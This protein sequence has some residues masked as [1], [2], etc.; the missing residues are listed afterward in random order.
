[1]K[2]ASEVSTGQMFAVKILEKNHIIKEKKIEWVEREKNLL[3]KLSH[4]AIITLYYTFQDHHF[5]YFVLELCPGG[6]FLDIIRKH[7]GLSIPCAVHYM[8]E[9]TSAVEYLHSMGVIHRDLKPENMLLTADNHIKLIDFGTAKEI[10]TGPS[11]RTTS[12][13]GTA[14]YLAPEILSSRQDNGY[15]LLADVWALGCV[16]YQ[17]LAGRC[18]FRAKVPLLIFQLIQARNFVYPEGFPEGPPMDLVEQLLNPNE[19]LRLGAKGYGEIK[20]HPFFASLT[21]WNSLQQRT[22]PPFAPPDTP[23]VWPPPPPEE[24]QETPEERQEREAGEA[25]RVKLEEQKRSVWAPFLRDDE[26]IVETGLIHKKKGLFSRRRQLFITDL[27]RIFYVDPEKMEKKGEIPWSRD[28]HPEIRNNRQFFIH[29]PNRTYILDDSNSSSH[30]WSEAIQ[31]LKRLQAEKV[32][33][34]SQ[35]ASLNL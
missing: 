16:L 29:T 20:S 25:R 30:R 35:T 5:L 26:L 27:P 3:D 28:I 14:E 31:R 32:A 18:P 19:Q 24:K 33:D 6:E 1:V 21:D 12:F 4:P 17:M 10:G 2:L 23:I 7:S 8:A 13:C 22:P 11:A 9:I 34:T 15:G